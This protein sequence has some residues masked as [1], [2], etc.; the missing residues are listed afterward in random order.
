VA[1]WHPREAKVVFIVGP[2][3]PSAEWDYGP[4]RRQGVVVDAHRPGVA[5]NLDARDLMPP[6]TP[7]ALRGGSH[8]HV[9]S[10]DGARVSFTYEDH[11]LSQFPDGDTAHDGNQRNVGVSVIGK[12][13][14]VPK[15]HV[16]NHDGSA[17]SVVVTRTTAHPRP[18][19]DD[20]SRAFEDGWVGTGGYLR[21]DGTRQ[22]YALAFQGQVVTARGETI[23]EVFI[24][25]LPGDL[26]A[27]GDGPLEGTATRRPAPPQGTTQRRLTFTP[28]R[29]YPG[30]RG[31]RHWLRSSP[32]GSR[33]GFLMGDDD[34][35]VQFWTV[36]PNGG[37]PVRVTRN[38]HPVASAF[39]WHPDG[40]RVAFVAD[41]RVCVSDLTTG[42]TTPLTSSCDRATAPRAE[43]CVFSPD[44]SRIA[45][46]RRMPTEGGMSNQIWVVTLD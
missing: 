40:R 45:F 20:I 16:R 18:G 5:V 1:T 9:F 19:S 41:G 26:T 25:D 15:T 32:D 17:F 46:I 39:T 44:G 6:F 35:V 23:S 31:P 13:V 42:V 24:V 43:A 21:A 3:F 10:P 27:P 4:A 11:V 38:P 30:I 2:E 28:A 14:T 29:R 36:S 22:R 7:G 33:I 37:D 12:P 8:V 34:G